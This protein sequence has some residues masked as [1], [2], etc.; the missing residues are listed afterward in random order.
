M[1]FNISTALLATALLATGCANN[2]DG[3]DGGGISDGPAVPGSSQDF[4]NSVNDR[5]HFGYDKSDISSE[6]STT[7]SEQSAWLK[8]YPNVN[9][10]LEGHADVRGTREYNL[11]LSEKRAINTKHA[12]RAA[13]VEAGRMDT[14]A[15]G[16]DQLVAEGDNEETHQANRVVITQPR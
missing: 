6:A 10:T 13:G 11:A 8:Q 1:K 5:V 9:V 12:L 2:T 16:K 14:N 4:R 15:L 7:L 3:Q